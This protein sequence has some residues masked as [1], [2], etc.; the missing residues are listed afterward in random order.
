MPSDGT[1]VGIRDFARDGV[2]TQTNADERKI[3]VHL[4]PVKKADDLKP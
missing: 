4:N 1:M 3:G 2:K